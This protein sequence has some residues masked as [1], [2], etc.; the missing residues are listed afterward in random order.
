MVLFNCPGDTEN[1]R[2]GEEG[3]ITSSWVFAIISERGGRMLG[4]ENM[5][6]PKSESESEN[7][8]ES[9]RTSERATEKGEE[10]ERETEREQ[11]N[12]RE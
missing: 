1:E 5:R 9:K 12:T 2:G 6:A 11:E 7:E 10:R 4:C 3:G 8:S